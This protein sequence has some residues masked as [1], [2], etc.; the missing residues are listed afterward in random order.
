MFYGDNMRWWIGF[1]AND[2]NDP[3]ECGR[4]QVRIQGIHSNDEQ[5]VKT[6]DLPWAQTI[7]PCTEPGVSG[8]GFGPQLKTG[9]QVIGFFLDGPMSQLPIIIGSIPRVEVPNELQEKIEKGTSQYGTYA[10]PANDPYAE[11]GRPIYNQSK[12]SS[13]VGGS[14]EYPS[15]CNPAWIISTVRAAALEGNRNIDPDIAE[16]VVRSEGLS[17]YQ[18]LNRNGKNLVRHNG[19]EASF[20]PFQ[21]YRIKG[22]GAEY[23]NTTGRNLIV[24]NNRAGIKLQIE[25][26]LDRAIRRG[27]WKAWYGW[28]GTRNKPKNSP[29]A[30]FNYRG[31]KSEAMRF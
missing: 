23:E 26:A 22:M 14:P 7:L 8:L 17:R 31:K 1:V 4:V 29:T 11:P 12:N 20:G 10:N 2:V 13:T 3:L 27:N 24:D 9:A 16:G 30:G 19:S 18:S 5:D 21:L 6:Y 28:V 25:F 15:D